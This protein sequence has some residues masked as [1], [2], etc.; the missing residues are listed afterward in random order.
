MSIHSSQ[1]PVQHAQSSAPSHKAGFWT[2]FGVGC[3]VSLVGAL[4]LGA[5]AVIL[6]MAAG[7]VD[8][9]DQ[10]REALAASQSTQSGPD[11][12]I[13]VEVT[14]APTPPPG[15]AAAPP[16]DDEQAMSIEELAIDSALDNQ[17][18]DTAEKV[19][20]ELV[21][22]NPGDPS[23][24]AL[25]Q[26]VRIERAVAAGDISSADALFSEAREMAMEIEPSTALGVAELWIVEGEPARGLV[27]ADAVLKATTG[28]TE[29]DRYARGAALLIRGL[30]KSELGDP[31]AGASDVQAAIEL[32]PDEETAAEWQDFLDEI[33]AKSR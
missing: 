8:A 25:L 9:R 18:Y 13:E 6:A 7:L 16:M 23:A 21:A 29:F 24:R 28:N 33:R 26:G 15:N 10:A 22:R 27:I 11:P 31:Q 20:R 12:T 32:A 1:P 4:I 17:D 30:A 3:A 2:G 19:A 14:E 5:I